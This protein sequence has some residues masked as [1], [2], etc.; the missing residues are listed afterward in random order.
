MKMTRKLIPAFVML[1]VS[2]IMLS[3]ASFAWLASNMT[4]DTGKMTV[5]ANTDVAFLQIADA[6]KTAWGRSANA[7]NASSGNLELVNA[8]VKTEGENRLIAWRI[9]TGAEPGNYVM[10]GNYSDVTAVVNNPKP[11]GAQ[12]AV[13]TRDQYVLYNTFYVR[14][15][16]ATS[17]LTNLKISEVTVDGAIATESFDESLRVLVVATD[18]G[19][20]VLGYQ[21]YDLGTKSLSTTESF[22]TS[23][24][25]SATVDQ[26][27]IKLDVYIYFDGEDEKAYTY[28]IQSTAERTIAVS[29]TAT[30]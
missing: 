13:G 17:T 3:T 30:K 19:D 24:I 20:K 1:I 25:L 8:Y 23:D 15:S 9:A 28:N 11:Q 18:T 10:T 27:E 6:D 21:C 14:M 4:V 2:A 16:N 29:F 26:N 5:K 12:S 22:K 7:T